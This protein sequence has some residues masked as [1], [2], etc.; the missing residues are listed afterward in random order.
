MIA[1]FPY[2]PEWKLTAGPM[3]ETGKGL[4]PPA[5]SRGFVDSFVVLAGGHSVQVNPKKGTVCRGSEVV[6][7]VAPGELIWKRTMRFY[8]GTHD[9]YTRAPQCQNYF[10]GIKVGGHEVGLILLE[11]GRTIPEIS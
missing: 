2:T 6:H 5:V 7:R 8:I 4:I 3:T 11:D 1:P 9:S 10:V